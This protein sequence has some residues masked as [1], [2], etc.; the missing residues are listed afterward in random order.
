MGPIS[1]QAQP[2]PARPQQNEPNKGTH[3]RAAAKLLPV[4]EKA[5]PAPTASA[6]SAKAAKGPRVESAPTAAAW[7]ATTAHAGGGSAIF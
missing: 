6:P 4:E 7:A 1:N 5:R 3:R 2:I